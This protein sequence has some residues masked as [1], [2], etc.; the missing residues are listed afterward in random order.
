MMQKMGQCG[1]SCDQATA[2]ALGWIL[3]AKT[4]LSW[5]GQRSFGQ[6]QPTV[7]RLRR[8]GQAWAMDMGFPLL[9]PMIPI[10]WTANNPELGKFLPNHP[11]LAA[12][13]FDSKVSFETRAI[14]GFLMGVERF[15]GRVGMDLV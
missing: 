4:E 14:A 3:R 11:L 2:L 12:P 1:V 15:N 13:S 5:A 10:V 9:L 8:D 6:R 7:L